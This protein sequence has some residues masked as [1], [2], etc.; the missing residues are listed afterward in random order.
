M[1]RF[2]RWLRW[3]MTRRIEVTGVIR[4]IIAERLL[5]ATALVAGGVVLLVVNLNTNLADV[6][7]RI[8]TDLNL[9]PGRG[10]LRRGVDS[11]IIRFG[12]FSSAQRNGIAIGALLYAALEGTEAAGLVLRRRW[13]EYLVLLATGA[14]I[15][16]EVDEVLFHPSVLKVLALMVNLLIIGYL[17]RR[18]RLFLERQGRPSVEDAA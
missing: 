2:G 12:S 6:A 15:P 11:A 7:Q 18:K 16:L 9:N 17:V 13:A 5:K 1:G 3:E 14:F 4:L 10:L 8:Q